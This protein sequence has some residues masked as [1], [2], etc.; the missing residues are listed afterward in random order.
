MARTN[1]HITDKIDF[2]CRND[3]VLVRIVDIGKMGNIALPDTAVE[4]KQFF[5]HAVG[6]LVKDLEPGD[7]VLMLGRKNDTYWELPFGR[8]MIVI[9]QENVVLKMKRKVVVE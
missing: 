4:G 9:K 6:P 5:V 3:T 2:T 8:D 1:L 7:E